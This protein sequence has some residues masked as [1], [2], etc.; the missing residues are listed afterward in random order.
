MQATATPCLR[1]IGWT[2]P[3]NI[4]YSKVA[5][6]ALK[7]AKNN[8]VP[9]AEHPLNVAVIWLHEAL[10]VAPWSNYSSNTGR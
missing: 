7:G 5:D 10:K 1:S 2:G 9:D 3:S 6:K 4:M 8:P